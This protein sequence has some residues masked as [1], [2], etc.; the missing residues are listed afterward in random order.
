MKQKN[1][2]GNQHIFLYLIY[3]QNKKKC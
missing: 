3:I 1:V 2:P